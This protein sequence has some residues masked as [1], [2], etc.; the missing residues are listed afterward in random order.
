MVVTAE[1]G[2]EKILEVYT[3][4]L[5]PALGT[6]LSY[7]C[8][9]APATAVTPTPPSPSPPMPSDLSTSTNS[10]HA[11]VP[12]NPRPRA[13]KPKP[14]NGHGNGYAHGLAPL[15]PTPSSAAALRTPTNDCPFLRTSSPRARQ[16]RRGAPSPAHR[17]GGET[18]S[19]S[20]ERRP[21]WSYVPHTRGHNYRRIVADRVNTNHA[22]PLHPLCTFLHS[23]RH[24][25]STSDAPALSS[26][27]FATDVV[28][29][30]PI[31]PYFVCGGHGCRVG[32]SWG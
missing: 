22:S 2:Y 15:T 5:L 1:D 9:A 26:E 31:S 10:T 8:R 30:S 24:P 27:F 16:Q 13:S 29:E 28:G 20:T 18:Q 3:L 4:N 12:T 7:L 14:G 17:N 6:R 11:V 19:P 21:T 25:T 23:L 32:C